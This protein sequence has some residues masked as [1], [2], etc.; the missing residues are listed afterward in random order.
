MVLRIFI[1]GMLII[2]PIIIQNTGASK[3][4][5][6]YFIA[7]TFIS[8]LLG[9]WISGMFMPKIIHPKVMLMYSVFPIALFLVIM[10]QCSTYFP[11]LFT[12]LALSFFSGVNINSNAILTALFS[13]QE[14]VSTNFG[15]LGLG[16]IS[17]TILGNLII[18]S[19]IGFWGNKIAFFLFAILFLLSN[20]LLLLI[21]KPAILSEENALN[22]TFK[23]DRKLCSLLAAS[24]MIIMLIHLFKM[25]LTLELTK[26]GYSIKYIS[27]LSAIAT[28]SVLPIPYLFGIAS[29]YLNPKILLGFCYILTIAALTILISTLNYYATI[30][31]IAF[32][33]ILAYGS[34][35]PVVALLYKWHNKETMPK[36]QTYYGS[37]AWMAAIIGYTLTGQLLEQTS[38]HTTILI[39]I[40]I[41]ITAIFVLWLG[42][43]SQNNLK[44]H[45][46]F[47][48]LTPRTPD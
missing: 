8:S 47:D 27:Y 31:S 7:A 36:A 21:E 22:K 14:S 6:G 42:V 2:Y 28:F 20:I 30:I 13:N 29:R 45:R 4:A 11:L 41:A 5:T 15:W 39:G 37:V 17:S 23:I 35:I 10:G 40:S 38:F 16:N 24:L 32:I 48:K 34:Y 43:N 19:A 9:T 25:S 1:Q 46:L 12:A 18:G 44:R 3:S 26:N 33:S